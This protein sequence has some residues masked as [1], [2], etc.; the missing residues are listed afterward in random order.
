MFSKNEFVMYGVTGVCKIDDI[1]KE[2]TGDHRDVDYFIL[3]PIKD[4]RSKIMIPV[5]RGKD[6]MR[7]LVSRTEVKMYLQELKECEDIWESDLKERGKL[8]QERLKSG[9]FYQ[10]LLLSSAIWQEKEKK[11][12]E[13][14]KISMADEQIF[15]NA[16]NLVCEELSVSLGIEEEEIIELLTKYL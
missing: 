7:P 4:E 3:K 9:S 13:G 12:S 16:W 10:W 8:F 1:T 5:T 14:K 15:Q 11:K 6:R 2:S